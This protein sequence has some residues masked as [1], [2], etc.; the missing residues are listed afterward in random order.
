[1]SNVEKLIKGAQLLSEL[2][3]TDPVA[4]L[5]PLL[6]L[7]SRAILYRRAVTELHKARR[8]WADFAAVNDADDP[9]G[10]EHHQR[11]QSARQVLIAQDEE[12]TALLNQ[13]AASRGEEPVL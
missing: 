4:E 7:S 8:A 11:V 9:A 10:L 6:R 5:P 1:M 2:G 3:L 13:I 12:F